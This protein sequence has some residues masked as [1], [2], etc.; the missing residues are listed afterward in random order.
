MRI[1][2]IPAKVSSIFEENYH[3]WKKFFIHAALQNEAKYLE[4]GSIARGIWRYLVTFVFDP[5]HLPSIA[6]VNHRPFI[7]TDVPDCLIYSANQI[8][9]IRLN[10]INIKFGRKNRFIL[11][12]QCLERREST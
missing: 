1:F 5:V 3:P 12:V 10:S 2:I 11:S 9:V 4:P 6:S 7:W 8:L